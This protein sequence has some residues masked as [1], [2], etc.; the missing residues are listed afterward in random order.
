[1]AVATTL[2]NASITFNSASLQTVFV[3]GSLAVGVNQAA[4]A[5]TGSF[6]VTAQYQ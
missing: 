6:T 2:S 5:Y 3:G 1:M 4:G